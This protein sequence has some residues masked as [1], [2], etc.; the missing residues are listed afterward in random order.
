MALKNLFCKIPSNLCIHTEPILSSMSYCHSSCVKPQESLFTYTQRAPYVHN[1][2]LLYV[3][4]QRKPSPHTQDTPYVCNETTPGPPPDVPTSTQ[5]AD[6]SP[7]PY[8]YSTKQHLP[9]GLRNQDDNIHTAIPFVYSQGRRSWGGGGGGGGGAGGLQPPQYSDV[10]YSYHIL[11]ITISAPP[12]I[13][14]LIRP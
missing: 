13:T 3:H 14:T 11:H 9:R 1:P 2:P 12:I 6:I 4:S 8:T 10:L 7:L 5:Q